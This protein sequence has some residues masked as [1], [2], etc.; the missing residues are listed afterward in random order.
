MKIREK[1]K[2]KKYLYSWGSIYNP[3]TGEKL[4]IRVKCAYGKISWV[5]IT[6]YQES[7]EEIPVAIRYLFVDEESD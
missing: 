7:E 1:F 6:T 5:W 2:T 4:N 3:E